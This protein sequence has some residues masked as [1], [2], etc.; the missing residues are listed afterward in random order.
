MMFALTC[1]L[2]SYV[3]L[4]AVAPSSSQLV[5]DSVRIV[6]SQAVLDHTYAL[7]TPTCSCRYRGGSCRSL[8]GQRPNSGRLCRLPPAVRV[9]LRVVGPPSC[10]DVA[11]VVPVQGA[12]VRLWQANPNG[13]HA[14]ADECGAHLVTDGRGEVVYTASRPGAVTHGWELYSRRVTERD[15][16]THFVVSHKGNATTQYITQTGFITFAK[17]D[18]TRRDIGIQCQPHLS[19]AADRDGTLPSLDCVVTLSCTA[20]A[21]FES[22]R[23]GQTMDEFIRHVNRKQLNIRRRKA[24]TGC[25]RAKHVRKYFDKTSNGVLVELCNVNCPSEQCRTSGLMEFASTRQ[26]LYAVRLLE[27]LKEPDYC[28]GQEENCTSEAVLHMTGRSRGTPLLL[29]MSGLAHC[30]EQPTSGKRYVVFGLPLPSPQPDGARHRPASEPAPLPRFWA[31]SSFPI[32]RVMKRLF[33]E[34]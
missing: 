8:R 4:V 19:V 6:S 24:I 18:S 31:T 20:N 11:Q 30:C 16:V 2:L 13:L 12:E 9:N 10:S 14:C 22:R 32:G 21:S 34:F 3:A 33:R 26:D 17:T 25:P 1:V 15:G 27:V 29:D 5:P 23:A 7:S 28:E